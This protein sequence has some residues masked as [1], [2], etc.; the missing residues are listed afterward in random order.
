MADNA[1]ERR[2]NARNV[3]EQ[4]NDE[5][6]RTEGVS[7]PESPETEGAED[8]D[9]FTV[10]VQRIH[11][12]RR[13]SDNVAAAVTISCKEK[14]DVVE[15]NDEDEYEVVSGNS[16]TLNT[17][18]LNAVLC[19]ANEEIGLVLQRWQDNDVQVR[20]DLREGKITI[21]NANWKYSNANLTALLMGAT[22]KI[23]RIFHE[24]GDTIFDA[25][26]NPVKDEDGNDRMYKHMVFDTNVESLKF[27]K[28][29]LKNLD[30]ALE[31]CYGNF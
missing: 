18:V 11:V 24:E 9:V 29:G 3:A 26:G 14:F 28:P 22:L 27:S 10:H 8:N 17:V 2:R 4:P 6:I 25:D 19:D 1:N 7:A 21:S 20:Q 31:K 16:F 13:K 5:P 12:I 15:A 23:E 30:R